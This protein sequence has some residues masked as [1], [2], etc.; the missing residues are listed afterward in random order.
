MR[1]TQARF[2]H[3]K[4]EVQA[5]QPYLPF[6]TSVLWTRYLR[7]NVFLRISKESNRWCTLVLESSVTV[8][9]LPGAAQISVPRPVST[10][11]RHKPKHT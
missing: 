9:A 2:L 5:T 11:L 4:I 7:G 10:V 6:F 8:S 3:L 1:N